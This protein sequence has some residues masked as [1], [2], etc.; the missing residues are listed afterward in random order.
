MLGFRL[1][2]LLGL[3]LHLVSVG[4]RNRPILDN[5]ADPNRL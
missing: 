3:G 4:L 1:R 5:N 2:L